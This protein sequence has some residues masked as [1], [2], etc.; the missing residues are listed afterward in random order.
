MNPPDVARTDSSSSGPSD[1]ELLAGLGSVLSPDALVPTLVADGVGV[2]SWRTIHMELAVLEVAA[3]ESAL[4]V[5]SESP[6]RH[7]RFTTDAM[8]IDLAVEAN[9]RTRT[10]RFWVDPPGTSL[11]RIVGVDGTEVASSSTDEFGHLALDTPAGGLVRVEV[12]PQPQ[13]CTEWFQL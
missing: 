4:A 8:S 10:V 2:F 1:G 7:L 6:I 9:G 3:A 5:R 13:I 11:I 12:L